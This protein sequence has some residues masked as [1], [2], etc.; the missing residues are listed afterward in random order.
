MYALGNEY[1][2]NPM[3]SDRAHTS[4]YTFNI[5]T[6]NCENNQKIKNKHVLLEGTL[7]LS[8]AHTTTN[9]WHAKQ[10]GRAHV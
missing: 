9:N 6:F 4:L 7:G 10:I 5:I 2:N 3:V 8:I 1:E